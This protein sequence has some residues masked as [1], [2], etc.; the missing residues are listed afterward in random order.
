MKQKPRHSNLNRIS[1][2]QSDLHAA[3]A[4]MHV[5]LIL[6]EKKNGE[7]AE[8]RTRLDAIRSAYSLIDELNGINSR[9]N[10][11]NEKLQSTIL[12]LSKK[13]KELENEVVKLKAMINF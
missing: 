2:I 1:I 8:Q 6:W 13:I 5:Q 10:F 9:I 11:E 3:E 7:N 4:D 12:S